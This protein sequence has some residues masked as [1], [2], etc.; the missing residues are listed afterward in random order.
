MPVVHSPSV[1]VREAEG[2]AGVG[3]VV[4]VLVLVADGGEGS[5]GSGRRWWSDTGGVPVVGGLPC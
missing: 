4:A 2:V 5:A 1:M 3:W